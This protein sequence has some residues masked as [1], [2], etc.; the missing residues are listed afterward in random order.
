MR[1]GALQVILFQV[2]ENPGVSLAVAMGVRVRATTACELKPS[3]R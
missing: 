1:G 3:L 2:K